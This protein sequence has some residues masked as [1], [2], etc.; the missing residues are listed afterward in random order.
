MLHHMKE[1]TKHAKDN[2]SATKALNG[3]LLPQ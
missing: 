2:V 1:M 3:N